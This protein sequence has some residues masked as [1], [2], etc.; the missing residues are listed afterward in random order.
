MLAGE[1]NARAPVTRAM[2]RR[3]KAS[4]DAMAAVGTTEELARY[5]ATLACIYRRMFKELPADALPR[6]VVPYTGEHVQ[7]NVGRK[8]RD[9]AHL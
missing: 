4:L 1:A 6:G 9:G 7:D 5:F 8:R 2:L 3:A